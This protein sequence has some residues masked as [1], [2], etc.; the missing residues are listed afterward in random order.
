MKNLRGPT[1]P[2][3]GVVGPHLVSCTIVGLTAKKHMPTPF[4]VIFIAFH[5]VLSGF[6]PNFVSLYQVWS[7]K[8]G[9]SNF[10]VVL[11]INQNKKIKTNKKQTK[12]DNYETTTVRMEN[13]EIFTGIPENFQFLSWNRVNCW[14]YCPFR[15][16]SRNHVFTT[17]PLPP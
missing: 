13:K 11:K 2:T 9:L 8:F 10:D 6:D 5:R 7:I 15:E 16:L 4:F 12:N 14:K 1:T 17:E 3:V